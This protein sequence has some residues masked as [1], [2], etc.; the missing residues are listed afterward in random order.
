[1]ASPRDQQPGIR[2]LLV[3]DDLSNALTLAALLE[4]SGYVVDGAA[5]LA[6]ARALLVRSRYEAVLL[7]QHLG[8]GLGVELLPLLHAE[9]IPA[10]L[11]TGAPE[12]VD[13]Q[14]GF[15][16]IYHKGVDPDELQSTLRRLLAGSP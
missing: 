12:Y 3:E 15:A 8:D 11:L 5:S 1:M 16:A 13:P 4:D 2:V 9:A 7:D 14:H 6:T 10:I